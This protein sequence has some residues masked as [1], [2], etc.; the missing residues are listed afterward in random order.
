MMTN[1]DFENYDDD[2]NLSD[3]TYFEYIHRLSKLTESELREA[4][5][6]ADLEK[7]ALIR[8]WQRGFRAKLN[9]RALLDYLI[10]SY[11]SILE[12][13][14]YDEVEGEAL[15]QISDALTDEEIVQSQFHTAGSKV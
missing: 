2:T 8:Y 14:G 10:L 15:I 12:M 9:A 7:Q 5:G 4:K 3:D 1:D 11:P 6:N 13:A